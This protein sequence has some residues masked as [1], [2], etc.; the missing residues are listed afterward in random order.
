M[1][2][3]IGRL[4]ATIDEMGERD[5][6]IVIFASDNGCSAEVVKKGTGPIGSMTR[7]A[8]L[9]GD[10]ANVSNTPFRKFKNYSHEGGVNTPL[11]VRW[12]AVIKKGGGVSRW[13]G[14]FIDFMPTFVE[15]GKANYPDHLDGKAILPMEGE[16]FAKVIRGVNQP[17]SKPLCWEWSKGRAVRSGD[18]KLVSWK[19]KW[20]LYNLGVDATET[21]DLA[22]VKLKK[23]VELET[24]F[25]D[26]KGRMPKSTLSSKAKR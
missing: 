24:M 22:S 9:G 7:W 10:W 6:T 15:L 2:Q 8:S 4:L 26:W 20:E 5:N 19:G 11:I 14:H 21:Q 18:W 25:K 16:S 12:P 13:A 17:R 3:N 23:V 1:D